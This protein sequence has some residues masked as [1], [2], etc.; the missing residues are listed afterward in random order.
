MPVSIADDPLA[1]VVLGTGKMLSDFKLL[2]RFASTEEVISS[3]FSVLSLEAIQRVLN[4]LMICRR[5]PS[6]SRDR[7]VLDMVAIPSRH[8]SLTLLAGVL[9]AQI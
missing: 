6:G 8:R 4:A 1:S 3:Q 5:I 9:L 7:T 2:R